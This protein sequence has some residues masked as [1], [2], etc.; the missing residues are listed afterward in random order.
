M[1]SE[2][3]QM[4]A[5]GNGGMGGLGDILGG[6]GGMG[7]GDMAGMADLLGGAGGMPGMDDLA[8][9]LGDEGMAKEMAD[10]ASGNP[11]AMA[12]Q[13]GELKNDLASGQISDAEKKEMRSALS[14]MLGGAN[15]DDALRELDRTGGAGL[16]AQEREALAVLRQ[17]LG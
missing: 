15:L 17:A 2:L 14:S 13:L 11:D 4:M 5:G 8:K 6:A 10:L 1:A 12:A 9:M 16:G 7:L 3:M